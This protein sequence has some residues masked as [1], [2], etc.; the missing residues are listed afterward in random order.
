VA[1]EI[2]AAAVLAGGR[3]SRLGGDKATVELAGRPLLSYPA[4]AAREAGLPLLVVAKPATALPPV[5][6][7]I[8][9][10][11]SE[12][13]HPL[14]GVLAALRNGTA[15]SRPAAVL[16]LACDTPFLT[17]EL[18]TWLAEHDGAVLLEQDA[19]LQPLP[20]RYPA[21]LAPRLEQ[22][23]KQGEPMGRALAALGARVV[24]EPELAR[25]GEP[26]RLC[27]NVNEPADLAAA[28]SLLARARG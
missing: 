1:D 8:V 10:E 25:F 18:L 17:P 16:A 26:A 5:Q 24:G 19:R 12:P 9:R 7:Q 4:A 23:V 27:F 28:E 6:A 22:A 13:V 20:G 3:G 14:C 11:P 2:V 15:G 21:A